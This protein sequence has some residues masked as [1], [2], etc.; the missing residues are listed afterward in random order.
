MLTHLYSHGGGSCQLS[1]LYSQ[2]ISKAKDPSAWHVI[3]S[4]EGGCPANTKGNLDGGDGSTPGISEAKACTSDDQKDCVRSFNYTIPAGAQSGD[5]ILAW[6]WF[7]SVVRHSPN[8]RCLR[9]S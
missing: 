1:L 7:N 6:T 8:P 3:Y 4:I 2:D 5:A 9:Q